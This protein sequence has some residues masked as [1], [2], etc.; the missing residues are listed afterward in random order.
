MEQDYRDFERNSYA[1]GQ[2][3][4]I[5]RVSADRDFPDRRYIDARGV[6]KS[7]AEIE[8][9]RANKRRR[10]RRVMLRRILA[11]IIVLALLGGIVAAIFVL[12]EKG[13]SFSKKIDGTF[14]RDVDVTQ[15]VTSDIAIWLSDIEGMDIDA[16]WVGNRVEPYVVTETLTLTSSGS[17][18][19]AY[20]RTVDSDSYNKL[21]QKVN[22]DIDVL[23][24]EIVK[25]QLLAKGYSD[26]VSD[27]DASR[28]TTQVLGMSAS[29]YLSSNGV[30][31]APTQ[32]KLAEIVTGS[33][34]SQSGTYS[35]SGNEMTISINGV[36]TTETIIRKKGV[37]VF[38]QS[39]RVYDE[40]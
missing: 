7:P 39:S 34:D 15:I 21:T 9:R 38:T 8:R 2:R 26:S 24:A 19:N 36:E 27:D 16:Q 30:S 11:V 31:V 6:D 29:E 22:T 3:R 20:I 35:I 14:T 25:E 32:E 12:K 33:S 37:L 40:K 13:I 4:P 5:D 10:R 28:I 1:Q 18:G 23:L 17:S